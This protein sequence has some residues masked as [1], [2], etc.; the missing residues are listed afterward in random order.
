MLKIVDKG[1]IRKAGNLFSPNSLKKIIN[2]YRNE[3]FGSVSV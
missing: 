1:I 2:R 3:K